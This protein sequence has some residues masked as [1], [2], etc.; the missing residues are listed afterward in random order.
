MT[1]MPQ[2]VPQTMQTKSY[3]CLL[4]SILMSVFSAGAALAKPAAETSTA[5][6]HYVIYLLAGQSNMDGRGN[7]ADLKGTLQK[8]AKPMP[9]VLIH[10]SAGGLRRP[11]R[12]NSGFDPLAPG[13][14]GSN[15]TSNSFGPELGFGHAMAQASPHEKI[16]LVKFS[17]GGTSLSADWTLNDPKKLYVQFIKFVKTT[18]E[19]IDEAGGDCEIRGMLWMQGESD[20]NL[21]DGAY[22]DL[23]TKLIAKTRADLNLPKLPFIIGQV[24]DD[25]KRDFV[26]AAQKAVAKEVPATA[27]VKSSGL[28]TTDNG[29]HFDAKSQ[30]ELGRRFAKEMQRLTPPS[31]K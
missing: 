3:K 21:P 6:P 18:Q 19:K 27:F 28:T 22:K 15:A 17:E 5:K 13:F 12:T 9:E 11:L 26:I 20:A 24:C 8:Y 10:F 2:C 31:K 16:L 4:V 29:T 1:I 23:L 30:I 25:G 14:S 7:V